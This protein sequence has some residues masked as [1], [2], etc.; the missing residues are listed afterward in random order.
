MWYRFAKEN[1]KGSLHIFDVDETL[2]KTTAK[3][4]VRSKI[5]NSILYEL[6]NQQFNDYNLGENEYY[7]FSQFEQAEKLKESEPIVPMIRKLKAIYRNIQK[8]PNSRMIIN[9]ARADFDD[10]DTVL[11][12]FRSLGIPIDQM[13][14]ERAGNLP[15]NISPA[16]KKN[17]ILRN[18]YLTEGHNYKKVY[19]Y[20]DSTTNLDVFKQLQQ[21]HPDVEFLPIHVQHGGSTRK[22]DDKYRQEVLTKQ[23]EEAVEPEQDQEEAPKI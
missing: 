8:N 19:F 7:D 9:T 15:G 17:E 16:F 5:D 1:Q 3:I 13:H 10:K 21:E 2:L 20:D 12:Y 18:K 6:T 14:I 22:W 11:E 4:L 23:K